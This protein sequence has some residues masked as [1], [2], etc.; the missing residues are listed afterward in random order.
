MCI[1]QFSCN[2]EAKVW[3]F[4]REFLGI[5]KCQMLSSSNKVWSAYRGHTLARMDWPKSLILRIDCNEF[6]NTAMGIIDGAFW[7]I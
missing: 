4:L 5:A 1:P 2:R 6:R 3:A 7:V